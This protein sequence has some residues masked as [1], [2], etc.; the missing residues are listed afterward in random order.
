MFDDHDANFLVQ[1]TGRK[2]RLGAG[3]PD[4]S[5]YNVPK[6]ENITKMTIGKY[7]E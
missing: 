7:T 2:T 4:L 1:K 3:L 6:W 5:W